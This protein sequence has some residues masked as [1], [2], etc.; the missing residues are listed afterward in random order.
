[1]KTRSTAALSMP[2]GIAIG[3]VAIQGLHAQAKPK[4]YTVTELQTLDAKAAADVA[5]RIQAAQTSAGGRYF[6]TGGGKVVGMEGPPPPQRVA[7]T[8]WIALRK[9]RPSSNRRPGL[10]S[11]RTVT[12][13]SRPSADM[14]S[15]SSTSKASYV[16][17][18]EA[19]LSWRPRPP[20]QTASQ[21]AP[22]LPQGFYQSPSRS[23][24]WR[25]PRRARRS[26]RVIGRGDVPQL[27]SLRRE[28][29][30]REGRTRRPLHH[31][32]ATVRSRLAVVA[33]GG[34]SASRRPK[35]HKPARPQRAAEFC[36]ESSYQQTPSVL[37]LA[38]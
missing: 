26:Y 9:Q 23:S 15:K 29:L 10:I 32:E 37:R 22:A 33:G 20:A 11:A 2:A 3:A 27:F 25:S 17:G 18:V 30:V 36:K 19:A 38:T 7:I 31:D 21:Q 12:R 5:K 4:A 1:M 24:A 35:T 8:E 6:R 16:A 28:G 13:R 14:G 34:Q